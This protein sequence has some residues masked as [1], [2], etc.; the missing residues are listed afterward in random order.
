MSLIT[1]ELAK[2]HLRVDGDDE[3]QLIALYTDAAEETAME[4]INRTV[5]ADADELA[6]AVLAGTAGQDPMVVTKSI[7]AAI[8]LIL[9][10]LYANREDTVVGTIVASLPRGAQALLQPYRVQMGV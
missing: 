10:D 4:F 1:P 2:L 8:L 3:D 7:Q 5:Y 9:G 6:D